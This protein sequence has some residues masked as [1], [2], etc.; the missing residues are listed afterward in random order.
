MCGVCEVGKARVE[1]WGHRDIVESL[2]FTGI[3]VTGS[4]LDLNFGVLE[5][6]PTQLCNY[7]FNI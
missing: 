1:T 5:S 3:V 4:V 7:L 6:S 2:P